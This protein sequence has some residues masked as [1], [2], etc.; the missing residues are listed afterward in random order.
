MIAYLLYIL[1][2]A[3]EIRLDRLDILV[4]PGREQEQAGQGT[5]HTAP[6]I[7]VLAVAP[8]SEEIGGLLDDCL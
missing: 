1:G 4:I 3:V 7:H 5:G 2:K 8:V 6:G